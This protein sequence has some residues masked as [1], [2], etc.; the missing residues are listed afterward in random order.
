MSGAFF[1]LWR[2]ARGRAG[3]WR[4]TMRL[5]R[6][7]ESA[8]RPPWLTRPMRAAGAGAA[9]PEKRL[10]G[11]ARRTPLWRWAPVSSNWG[12][13]LSTRADLIGARTRRRSGAASRSPAALSSGRGAGGRS[14]SNTA[15][16]WSRCSTRSTIAPSPRLPSPRS[17]MR[18]PRTGVR[19]RSRCCGPAST[20]GVPARSRAVSPARPRGG[21]RAPAVAALP[22]RRIGGGFRRRCDGRDENLSLEGAAAAELAENFAGDASLGVPKVDWRRTA[23]AGCSPP[24]ASRARRW[25]TPRL[26]PPPATT[27]PT[28]SRAAAAGDVQP[29]LPRR[30]FPWRPA[31]G[32][33]FRRRGRFRCGWWISAVMG[34]LD[35]AT[36]RFLADVLTGFLEGDYARGR[37]GAFR[38]GLRVRRT[39]RAARSAQ[40]LRAIGRAD[41]RFAD[42]RN[43]AG[44]AA[45]AIV[46]HRRGFRDAG[47]AAA[48]AAPEGHGGVGGGWGGALHPGA[49]MW[50]L[51]RPAGGG[52][53]RSPYGAARAGAGGAGRD[54]GIRAAPAAH[55]GLRR[56]GSGAPCGRGGASG[57]GGAGAAGAAGRRARRRFPRRRRR[58]SRR[59]SSPA[60]PGCFDAVAPGL[61]FRRPRPRGRRSPGRAGASPAR[62]LPPGAPPAYSMASTR[63]VHLSSLATARHG[64]ARVEVRSNMSWQAAR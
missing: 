13:A 57:A 1:D 42:R 60:L 39:P 12:Q 33:H 48:A 37:G 50:E 8:R 34:R 3:C 53:G 49:N 36:R 40:A 41:S 23:P 62:R 32:E 58:P 61:G 63:A 25:A 14:P 52:L 11:G 47:P 4:G 6:S 31:S 20:R 30:L 10:G 5:R 17:T 56:N 55:G 46:S 35:R 7:K 45:G 22:P 44:A 21:A 29:G 51:A 16:R 54:G 38:D 9:A 26:S 19:S 28:S 43:L 59:R 15:R 18:S 27:P 64:A 24:S 2:L